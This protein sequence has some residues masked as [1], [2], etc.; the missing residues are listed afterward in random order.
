MIFR[1]SMA[2]SSMKVEGPQV[3]PGELPAREQAL[4]LRLYR[5][6]GVLVVLRVKVVGEKVRHVLVVMAG[7]GEVH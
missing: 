4:Q 7:L 6:F 3:R 1:S 2:F 5:V